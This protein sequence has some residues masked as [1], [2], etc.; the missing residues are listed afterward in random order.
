MEV[1]HRDY[2][3]TFSVTI[4]DVDM[5]SGTCS[6]QYYRIGKWQENQSLLNFEVVSKLGVTPTIPSP[7]MKEKAPIAEKS[8]LPPHKPKSITKSSETIALEERRQ[9]RKAELSKYQREEKAS[10]DRKERVN[11]LQKNWKN[12][13]EHHPIRVDF[14]NR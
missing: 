7:K 13:K 11:K 1:G 12:K 2:G 10:S 4:R 5:N 9:K 8:I 6:I 14:Y 3:K